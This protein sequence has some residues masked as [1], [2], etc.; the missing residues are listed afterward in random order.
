MLLPGIDDDRFRAVYADPPWEEHGAGKV[1]RGARRHYPT[2]KLRDMPAVM[3]GAKD[4]DGLP[5]WRPAANSHLYLWVTNTFLEGG[6]WLMGELGFVYKTNLPWSKLR[7]T[8]EECIERALASSD[9]PAEQVREAVRLARMTRQNLGQYFRGES[10]LLL[11]GVRGKGMDPSVYQ[12]RRNLGT[13]IIE[14]HVRDERGKVKHSGKPLSVYDRIEARS[15]GPYL[16]LFAR[17][18]RPGWTS[19]GN[20]LAAA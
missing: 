2:V 18:G 5:L 12:D 1:K 8:D 6:L 9:D 4:A 20:Q 11:F 10:E 15:K 19:W 14:P 13:A 3:K 16:E 7:Y 17:S